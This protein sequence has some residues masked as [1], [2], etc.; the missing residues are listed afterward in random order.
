MALV[1]VP[2]RSPEPGVLVERLRDVHLRM[3]DAVLSGDGLGR[4]AALAAEATGSGVAIVVPR[5]GAAV[6]AAPHGAAVDDAGTAEEADAHI[7]PLARYVAERLRERPVPVPETVSA[8][9]PIAAGDEKLGAVLLVGGRASAH[10]AEFL[11]LAAVACLTE[12]AVEEAREEVE[13]NLRGTFLEELRGRPDLEPRE[14]V[15]RAGRLGCDLTRGA[16]ALCAALTTTRPRLVVAT[17]DVQTVVDTIL[18]HARTGSIGDG[19]VFV[20]PVE[21]AYRIRTGESGEETLQ[22]H[23]DAAAV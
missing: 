16:V 9:V 11:H 18:R 3:V 20:V 12:V 7:E 8:E 19:K 15:R 2:A 4:V 1:D 5:L 14:I 10:A 21:E 22:A 23:P 6:L 13:Q 17:R